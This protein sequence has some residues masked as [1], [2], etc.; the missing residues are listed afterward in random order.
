MYAAGGDSDEDTR[1]MACEALNA[2]KNTAQYKSIG[3]A[4]EIGMKPQ[5]DRKKLDWQAQLFTV[6]VQYWETGTTPDELDDE[7]FDEMIER[8]TP[9][10]LEEKRLQY[11]KL[12][13]LKSLTRKST[14]PKS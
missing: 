9:L 5:N 3:N 14:V 8:V 6:L 4:E 13:K 1:K 10:A 11:E 7:W 2:K 12:K